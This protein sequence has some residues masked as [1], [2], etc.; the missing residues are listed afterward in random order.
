[1]NISEFSLQMVVDELV[2]SLNWSW[3]R[4]GYS[5]WNDTYYELVH[6]MDP[7]VKRSRGV[8]CNTP[9]VNPMDCAIIA[10]ALSGAFT[11]SMSPQGHEYW[12]ERHTKLMVYSYTYKLED[13]EEEK[14]DLYGDYDRAMGIL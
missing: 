2:S 14:K 3:S 13:Q 12:K 6:L 5:Y 7:T 1:M 4:E 9:T 10:G 8:V 11:W